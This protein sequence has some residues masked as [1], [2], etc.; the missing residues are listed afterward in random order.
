MKMQKSYRT[1]STTARPTARRAALNRL[2][3]LRP[4]ERMSRRDRS[5][6]VTAPRVFQTRRHMK[7]EGPDYLPQLF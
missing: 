3:P 6:T 5:G 1:R 2:A 4:P 7:P